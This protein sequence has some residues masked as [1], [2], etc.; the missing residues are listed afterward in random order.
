MREVTSVKSGALLKRGLL[1][2]YASVAW[3]TVEGAGAILA[4]VFA[5]SLA[6]MAFGGDSIVELLSSLTVL[7]HYSPMLLAL[8]R[9]RLFSVF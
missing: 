8:N 6:L 2:E 3:M 7:E 9:S 1:I 5:G 4:G